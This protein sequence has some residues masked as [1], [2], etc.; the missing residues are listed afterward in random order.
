MG[1]FLPFNPALPGN[2]WFPA[3]CSAMARIISMRYSAF[4][5]QDPRA[6]QTWFLTLLIQHPSAMQLKTKILS[7]SWLALKNPPKKA[8]KN[9][10]KKPLKMFFLDFFGFFKFLIFYE[11]NT[12]F[13]YEQGR[14]SLSGIGFLPEPGSHTDIFISLVTILLVKYSSILLK[15]APIFSFSNSKL[16]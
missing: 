1:F 14:H 6:Y 5:L 16:T 13:F 15:L 2:V 3:T 4:P 11:K 9:H 12:N 10:L 8:Q 7:K